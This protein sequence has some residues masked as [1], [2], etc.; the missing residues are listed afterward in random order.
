LSKALFHVPCPGCG[1]THSFVYLAQGRPRESLRWHRIG[2]ILYAYFVYQVFFR[3]A[4]LRRPQRIEAPVWIDV[5]HYAALGVI[6]LLFLNWIAGAWCGG[7]G[8]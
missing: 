2:A 3:I 7:N 5:Q 4:I 6:A 8:M 1:L